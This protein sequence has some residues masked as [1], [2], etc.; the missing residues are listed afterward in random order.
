MT[1]D[2]RK[3]LY[4]PGDILID[5]Q[6]EP[7]RIVAIED[8]EFT[9]TSGRLLRL[10]VGFV[11]EPIAFA[12]YRFPTD[13]ELALLRLLDPSAGGPTLPD[14]TKIR[15]GETMHQPMYSTLVMPSQETLAKFLMPLVP[16]PKPRKPSQRSRKKRRR[17]RG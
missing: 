10:D 14:G 8:D 5:D 3:E 16:E 11:R 15:F 9:S 6:G 12:R 1:D 2:E 7:C 17:G 13:A 4:R